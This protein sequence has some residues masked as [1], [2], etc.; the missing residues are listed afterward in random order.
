MNP[1]YFKYIS[2]IILIYKH[3]SYIFLHKITLIRLHS[4]NKNLTSYSFTTI[5]IIQFHPLMR[6]YQEIKHII[7][8]YEF[9]H[10]ILHNFKTQ[11]LEWVQQY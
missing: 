2:Q 5:I 1:L 8:I 10:L 9:L 11:E 3:R 4:M 6:F 7:D